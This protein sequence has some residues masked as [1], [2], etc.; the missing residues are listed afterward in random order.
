MGGGGTAASTDT[1]RGYWKG[2]LKIFSRNCW[3]REGGRN[4]PVIAYRSCTFL[5]KFF[6]KT[7]KFPRQKGGFEVNLVFTAT[8]ACTKRALYITKKGTFH[9]K[10][11]F[12]KIWAPPRFLRP[13]QYISKQCRSRLTM[14]TRFL[15]LSSTLLNVPSNLTWFYC[16]RSVNN[17]Y[18]T[19]NN[20]Y[21]AVSNLQLI[22]ERLSFAN[23]KLYN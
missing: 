21:K 5:T 13:W 18:V 1:S 9:H 7:W 15:Q 12:E 17:I 8:L 10:K 11:S 19:L 14:Y 4:F 20:L 22:Q 16:G 6:L 3:R 2:H 23:L